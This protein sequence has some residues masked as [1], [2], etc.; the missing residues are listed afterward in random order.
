M[1]A[2]GNFLYE[3]R[4]ER[5]MTQQELADR[6]HITN[7]AVSKWETGEAF[8]ETAQLIPLATIFGVTVD[9]LLRGERIA[10]DR[11]AEG[12]DVASEVPVMA[13][14]SPVPVPASP[15]PAL[16]GVKGKRRLSKRTRLILCAAAAVLIVL[17]CVLIPVVSCANNIFRIGKV[18][19]IAV[20]DDAAR[21]YELLGEPDDDRGSLLIYYDGGYDKLM[22]ELEEWMEGKSDPYAALESFK[23]ISERKFRC[24]LVDLTVGRKVESILFD[25]SVTAAGSG[26]KQ[27]REVSLVD[28]SILNKTIVYRAYYTDGSYFLGETDGTFV[29]GDDGAGIT[30]T[31]SWTD[32]FGNACSVPL[33]EG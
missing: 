16:Q 3:L 4:K 15:A 19:Q 32:Q 1:T 6:L 11:A 13:S 25:P 33:D 2:F 30:V 24:I 8:P 20:G 29:S 21:V 17:L 7:K 12:V 10:A 31:A 14:A 9:E 23:E 27:I 28:W 26:E 22:K 5:G 18:E